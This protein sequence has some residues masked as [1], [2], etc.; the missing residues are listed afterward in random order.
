M[1]CHVNNGYKLAKGVNPL[2]FAAG[3]TER[4]NE[5]Y[6]RCAYKVIAAQASDLLSA[7]ETQGQIVA[8]DLLAEAYNSLSQSSNPEP[9]NYRTQVWFGY[10][11][12]TDQNVMLFNGPAEV[13]AKFSSLHEVRNYS[14]I[15]SE[16]PQSVDS[17]KW[18]NRREVWHRVIPASGVYG[19]KMTL[20]TMDPLSRIVNLHSA[21]SQ[22]RIEQAMPT[23]QA[24]ARKLLID[25]LPSKLSS[26]GAS[27]PE[28]LKAIRAAEKIGQTNAL[29]SAI[30]YVS[31]LMAPS[32]VK[33]L[34]TSDAGQ[35]SSHTG[36][37]DRL[38]AQIASKHERQGE[39]A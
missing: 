33:T 7:A 22:Q 17:E 34:M 3:L 9:G 21:H 10:D 16:A 18:P 12:D 8:V 28:I 32:T 14:Y 37:I 2:K 25:R 39:S 35:V 24:R 4:L 36:I 29:D 23:I 27:L 15:D 26:T 11:K 20:W 1:G 5:E 13:E 19:E 31:T 6:Q 30:G 38:L